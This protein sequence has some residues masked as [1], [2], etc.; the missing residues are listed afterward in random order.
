LASGTPDLGSVIQLIIND[1][2]PEI[3]RG[4]FYHKQISPLPD[5]FGRRLD[6]WDRQSGAKNPRMLVES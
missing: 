2:P 5:F 6:S 4:R 3:Y 1:L